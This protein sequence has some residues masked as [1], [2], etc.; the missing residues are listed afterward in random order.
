MTQVSSE[1]ESEI[2]VSCGL[3]CDGTIFNYV[4]LKKRDHMEQYEKLNPKY[5]N[6]SL[7]F[8]QPCREFNCT[9]GCKIYAIRPSTCEEFR[10]HLLDELAA[11]HISRRGALDIII[12]AKSLRDGVMA[13]IDK[14]ISFLQPHSVNQKIQHLL[15]NYHSTSTS[16]VIRK[17]HARAFLQ[18]GMLRAHL[19]NHFW[20][21]V[22]DGDTNHSADL[23]SASR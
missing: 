16:L 12:K 5:E 6:D 4:A 11:G 15:E 8:Y 1:L 18:Y 23:M 10:C 17:I 19:N 2:C 13:D 14:I 9:S 21:I 3:C 22:Y 7:L 20:S